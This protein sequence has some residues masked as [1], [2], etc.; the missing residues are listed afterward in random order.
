MPPRS[1]E[2]A[3]TPERSDYIFKGKCF[4]RTV[5]GQGAFDSWRRVNA[6]PGRASSVSREVEARKVT[7][8]LG[9]P[10]LSAVAEQSEW[11]S[12]LGFQAV[13]ALEFGKQGSDRSNRTFQTEPWQPAEKI[14]RQSGQNTN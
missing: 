1:P 5:K 12:A 11:E 4:R 2:S 9:K 7:G 6:V 10:Q 8:S 13:G 14:H 3:S